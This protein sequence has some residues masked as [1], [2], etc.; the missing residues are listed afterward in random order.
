MR[1]K[2]YALTP[3]KLCAELI[4]M[5]YGNKPTLVR[6]TRALPLKRLV[7]LLFRWQKTTEKH[8]KIAIQQGLALIYYDLWQ[9]RN[10]RI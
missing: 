5:K 2:V 1:Y 10:V 6:N 7:R 3:L 9:R 8:V 4:D